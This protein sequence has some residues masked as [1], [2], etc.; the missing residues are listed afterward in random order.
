MTTRGRTEE[1]EREIK[2]I[3]ERVKEEYAYMDQLP[4]DGWMWEMMRRGAEYRTLQE[5]CL[6]ARNSI[7]QSR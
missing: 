5:E 1:E 2:D 3:A 4:L 6:V 7:L